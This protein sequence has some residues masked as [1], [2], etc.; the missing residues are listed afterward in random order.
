V[1][2]LNDPAY[3]APT[4]CVPK[5]AGAKDVPDEMSCVKI[6]AHPQYGHCSKPQ[7]ANCLPT[8]CYPAVSCPEAGPAAVVHDEPFKYDPGANTTTPLNST[9]NTAFNSTNGTD[10]SNSTNATVALVN[11]TLNHTD[12]S[13]PINASAGNISDVL[14]QE[15][16]KAAQSAARLDLAQAAISTREAE[17]FK[18]ASLELLAKLEDAVAHGNQTA[19]AIA[20]SA[21]LALLDRLEHGDTEAASKTW[22]AAEAVLEREELRLKW[23]R[24]QANAKFDSVQ[25]AKFAHF[26][27][28]AIASLETELAALDKEI[29]A[30]EQRVREARI[31]ATTAS[32]GTSKVDL[33]YSESRRNAALEE[34]H[35]AQEAHNETAIKIA[36]ADLARIDAEIAADKVKVAESHRD[37]ARGALADDRQLQKDIEQQGNQTQLLLSGLPPNDPQAR[38]VA[39]NLLATLGEEELETEKKIDEDDTIDKEAEQLAEE[40][41]KENEAKAGPDNGIHTVVSNTNGLSVDFSFL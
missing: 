28:A 23:Q 2:I 26:S 17:H 8:L 6:T 20:R 11:E 9:N 40:E 1:D 12:S 41:L 32:S 4:H 25:S 35:H 10:A 5:Y 29:A 18:N 14:V 3:V 27:D 34:L 15:Q 19:A 30:E 39:A 24:R 38:A 33:H 13:A 37:A 31:E 36:E 22:T 21:L 7:L 16:L